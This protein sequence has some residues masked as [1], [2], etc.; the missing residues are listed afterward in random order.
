MGWGERG[1]EKE[2]RKCQFRLVG[3]LVGWLAGWTYIQGRWMS[4]HSILTHYTVGER[5][6]EEGFK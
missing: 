4:L 3:W 2:G 6:R 1:R 5:R